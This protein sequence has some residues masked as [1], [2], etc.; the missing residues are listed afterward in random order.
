MDRIGKH[1]DLGELL[2]EEGLIIPEQLKAARAAQLTQE[3]SIGRVLVEMGLITEQAKM[4]FLHKKFG[5]EI[6]DIHGMIVPEHILTRVS[7]S[8]AERHRCAPILVD[9]GTLVIAMEDPTDIMVLDEIKQEASTEVLPVLAPI[10]DI[11]KAIAQ[12]PALTQQQVDALYRIKRQSPVWRVLHPLL[13]FVVML[14]PLAVF[15]LLA[16]KSGSFSNWVL[17]DRTPFDVALYGILGWVLWAIII[18]EIDGLFFGAD[19]AE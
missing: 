6:V 1:K 11:E 2:L 19:S 8:Y 15:L 12:Y 10:A 5:F 3:K 18:W 16:W 14:L 13:F 17:S 4:T 7:R 9:E